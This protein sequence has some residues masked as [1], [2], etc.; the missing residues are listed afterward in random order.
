MDSDS[1]VSLSNYAGMDY[2]RKDIAKLEKLVAEKRPEWSRQRRHWQRLG[3]GRFF[4]SPRRVLF[5]G[6]LPKP[7]RRQ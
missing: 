5:T 4:E 2:L 3:V 7:H 6:R 1:D